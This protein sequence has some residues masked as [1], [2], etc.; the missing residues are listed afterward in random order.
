MYNQTKLWCPVT[1]NELDTSYCDGDCINCPW[2]KY[3]KHDGEI[4]QDF[5]PDKSRQSCC[6]L[7]E[8]GI[9]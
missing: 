1:G 8:W 6:K 5:M 4:P 2:M 7:K 9:E 3:K